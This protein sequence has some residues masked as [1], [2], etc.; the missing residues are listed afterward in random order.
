MVYLVGAGV[1]SKQYIT[2]RG[3]E[4]IKNCEVLIYDRLLDDS[5]LKDTREDC[6]KIYVGKE[7]GNHAM[8][9]EEINRIL[10]ELAET[11]QRV[12]RLKG[13][14]S[15]VFG[16]GGEEAEALA[17]KG[18][19]YEL[20]PGITSAIAVPELCGIPVTHRGVSQDFHIVTGHTA[21]KDSINYQALAQMQG[22]LVFLMGVRSIG[23]IADKL[24]EH[25][26]SVETPMAFLE[27]GGTKRQR[28]FRTTLGEAENCVKENQIV[29]PSIIV[30]G[31]T[32]NLNFHCKKKK[33]AV[34]GT[35][36]FQDRLR[37][38]L[39]EYD[40]TE[41]GTM[42]IKPLEFSFDMDCAYLVFTSRN[43]VELFRKYLSNHHI[44]IRKLSNVKF[45][46]IGKGTY[47]TLAEYGIYAE[48]MPEKYTAEELSKSLGDCKG[49][50]V[51]LR[52]KNGSKD[53]CKYITD[54]E[55][56]PI[57]EIVPKNLCDTKADYVVFG[58]S[59]AV[60]AYC[61]KFEISGKP[62][63]IGEITAN[64]L[65]EHGY[66]PLVAGEYTVDGI[67]AVIEGCECER[68]SEE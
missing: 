38:K 66:A 45:A 19:S 3:L 13:G 17:D 58:S 33:I 6:K 24:I 27:N 65:R 4:L 64:A 18:I 34:L 50:K 41:I 47:E 26:K 1:G 10:V 8:K 32:V 57:Y 25:G 37:E 9:Q 15:F 36:N 2:V 67:W 44:D 21:K 23:R 46:V 14:D 30:I 53:L 55:D 39:W 42:E 31:E 62:V 11:Y 61:R 28:I 63:A 29:S 49:K 52:A 51:I 48:I 20:V 12:V 54:Y 60:R 43:G 68:K 56:I 7:V 5:L 40:V 59:S 16:R 35:K 22:T